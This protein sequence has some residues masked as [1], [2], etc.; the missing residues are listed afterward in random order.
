MY[1]YI[2]I[3]VDVLGLCMCLVWETFIAQTSCGSW[4]KPCL[5]PGIRVIA[6]YFQGSRQMGSGKTIVYQQCPE[7]L[8]AQSKSLEPPLVVLEASIR[9]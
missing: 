1:I 3:F 5:S 7:S 4:T 8:Q 2:Y 9:L 6:L